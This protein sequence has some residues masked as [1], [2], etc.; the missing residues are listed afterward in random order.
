MCGLSDLL[1]TR[2]PE[3]I[4]RQ[5]VCADFAVRT[6]MVGSA[7]A[8]VVC[9]RSTSLSPWIPSSARVCRVFYR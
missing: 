9:E 7:A 3:D 1:T 4:M 5:V 8:A 6:I 2:Q